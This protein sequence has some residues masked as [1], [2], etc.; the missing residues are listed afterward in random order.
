MSVLL[1]RVQECH[2][3]T[4]FGWLEF[5]SVTVLQCLGGQSSGVSQFYSVWG[6]RVQEFYRSTE[7]AWSEFRKDLDLPVTFTLHLD[8]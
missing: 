5:R 1:V 4:V 2:S 8:D 7:L 3:F 6:V